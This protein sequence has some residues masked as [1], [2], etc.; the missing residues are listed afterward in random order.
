[1]GEGDLMEAVGGVI[2]ADGKV[3]AA[4]RGGKD[5]TEEESASTGRSRDQDLDKERTPLAVDDELP[6]SSQRQWT[7]GLAAVGRE[8]FK[9]GRPGFSECL[10]SAE[11][12]SAECSAAT[13]VGGRIVDIY[14]AA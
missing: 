14:Y 5:T 10:G 4:G 6:A 9:D 1:M 11:W 12:A 13:L 2:V 8:W 3:A 7:C